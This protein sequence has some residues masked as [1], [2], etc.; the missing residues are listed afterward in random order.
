MVSINTYV[1]DGSFLTKSP[2]NLDCT[3]IEPSS[4]ISQGKY[5]FIP[6][7]KS[8]AVKVRILSFASISIPYKIGRL[9][10]EDTAFCTI[11]IALLSSFWLIF[12]FIID[13][14][15]IIFI[16]DKIILLA[17]VEKYNNNK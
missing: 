14:L 2:I 5:V 15:V 4:S 11:L 16:V 7:S 17:I 9:V 13:S 12:N 10:L 8:V 1:F 3:T 6:N